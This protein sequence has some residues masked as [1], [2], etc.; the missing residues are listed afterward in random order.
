M[1]DGA[2]AGGELIFHERLPRAS[3]ALLRE[4]VRRKRAGQKQDLALGFRTLL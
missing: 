4:I 1:K 3:P 2:R